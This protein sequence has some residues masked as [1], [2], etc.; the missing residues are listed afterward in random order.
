L[1]D[2]VEVSAAPT[3]GEQCYRQIRRKLLV[4]G[5]LPDQR[6]TVRQIATALSVSFTPAREALV[7]LSTE[8]ALVLGPRFFSVP[9][10]AIEEVEEIY[11]CRHL[12]ELD[13]AT[14]ALQKLRPADIDAIQ[15]LQNAMVAALAARDFTR[16]LEANHDFHF[17]IYAAAGMPIFRHMVEELWVRCGPSLNHVY[18]RL[19]HKPGHTHGHI[20]IMQAL[21][22]QNPAALRHALGNDLANGLESIRSATTQAAPASVP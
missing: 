8:G 2:L 19:Q 20:P 21:Q 1:L 13:L 16:A 22:D 12:L 9:R 17:A 11:R 3:R 5:F 10:L 6:L 7:R 14:N 15:A 4:G 18:P